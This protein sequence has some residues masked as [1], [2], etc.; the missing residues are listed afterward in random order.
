MTEW[1]LFKVNGLLVPNY[2]SRAAIDISRSLGNQNRFLQITWNDYRK[3]SRDLVFG[4]HLVFGLYTQTAP[5]IVDGSW[6]FY[7]A[8]L[9]A[10]I[11]TIIVF[12]L[13]F[14][15]WTLFENGCEGGFRYYLDDLRY[16]LENA[17]DHPNAVT[18][19]SKSE[20]SVQQLSLC[21]QNVRQLSAKCP[22]NVH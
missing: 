18:H 4:P 7:H 15:H 1:W 9:T 5:W 14:W 13:L 10:Y 21:P 17:P 6:L 3:K 22:P 20:A 16:G 8:T 11:V 2:R 19:W 12:L